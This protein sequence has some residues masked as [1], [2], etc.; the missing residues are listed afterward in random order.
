MTMPNIFWS[1][2]ARGFYLAGLNGEIPA[3]AIAITPEDH[4]ALLAGQ[5]EGQCIMPGA[6]GAPRTCANSVTPE[7]AIE[8]RRA[9]RNRQLDAC[10]WTQLADVPMA[11]ATRAAW[12]AYRQALRDLD[13]SGS[14]WPLS[15]EETA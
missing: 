12:V 7:D 1:A 13:M 14:D 6:D 8:A 5:A 11:D 9:A 2:S 15:P 10:D 3:D 4:A